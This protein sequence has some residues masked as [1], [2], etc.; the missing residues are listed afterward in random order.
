MKPSSPDNMQPKT[1]D[2]EIFDYLDDM[3]HEPEVDEQ[4]QQLQKL[5]STSALLREPDSAA[6]TTEAVDIP[7]QP[8]PKPASTATTEQESDR[9][10]WAQ[11]SFECLLF[12]VAGLKLAVPLVLLG[13]IYEIDKKLNELPGESEWFLGIL[14]A[15]AAGNIKVFNTTHYI[16]PERYEPSQINDLH[17]VISIHGCSWGLACDEVM[18]SLKISPDEVKWR[19]SRGKRPWLA[20]TVVDHM[21]SLVDAQGFQTIID[22]L[23]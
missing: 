8:E 15:G 11:N 7:P 3:L 22:Q 13:S 10:Y 20:G 23:D 19:S 18:Q 17:Y 16:M 12:K 1:T 6:V 2:Q 5:L 14:R 9:P 21:C 4:R